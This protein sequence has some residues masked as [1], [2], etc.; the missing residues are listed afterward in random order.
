MAACLLVSHL[1][2]FKKLP[3]AEDF[4]SISLIFI[5]PKVM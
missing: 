5:Q 1:I 3:L 4:I 2:D